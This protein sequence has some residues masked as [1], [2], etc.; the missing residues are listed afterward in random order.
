M[1]PKHPYSPNSLGA[2]RCTTCGFKKG[3]HSHDGFVP[4]TTVGPWNMQTLSALAP[5][6]PQMIGEPLQR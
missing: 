4:S 5:I 3:H 6:H 1:I 2:D